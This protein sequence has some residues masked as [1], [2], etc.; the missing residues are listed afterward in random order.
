[1]RRSGAPPASAIQ[2]RD[3][4]KE[5]DDDPTIEVVYHV[6][7]PMV[8]AAASVEA[9]LGVIGGADL[10]E[11]F[12]TSGVYLEYAR[13]FLHP[14]QIDPVDIA[15]AILYLASDESGFATGSSVVVDGGWIAQ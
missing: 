15:Q 11:L 12:L 13:R 10:F 4:H 8:D 9:S 5:L 6:L 3:L 2:V 14:E 1:M 7:L